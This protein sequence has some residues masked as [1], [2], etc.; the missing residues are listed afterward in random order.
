MS[1]LR[2]PTHFPPEQKKHAFQLGVVVC[3]TEIAAP[4]IAHSQSCGV[5]SVV[6][7]RGLAAR[8]PILQL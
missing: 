6:E 8:P 3:L 1:L 2:L 7:M 4:A 5:L